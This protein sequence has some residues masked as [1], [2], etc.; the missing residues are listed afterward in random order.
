M[1]D[2]S[3]FYSGGAADMVQASQS[4]STEDSDMSRGFSRT[5][6]DGALE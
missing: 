6:I 1:T 2:Y 4:A 5:S 3:Q